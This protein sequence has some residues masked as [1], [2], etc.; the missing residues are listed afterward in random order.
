MNPVKDSI[1]GFAKIPAI[2]AIPSML[3]KVA[4][5]VSFKPMMKSLPQTKREI[6]HFIHIFA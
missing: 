6:E 3:T 4:I 2:P 5:S 1:P